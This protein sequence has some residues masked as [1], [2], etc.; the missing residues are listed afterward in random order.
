MCGVVLHAGED[1]GNRPATTVVTSAEVG[2]QFAAAQ[3]AGS[4]S[5]MAR[6]GWSCTRAR[7]SERWSKGLIPRD[8][9]VATS[10]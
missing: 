1:V 8:L 9:Q 7:T 2:V 3:P 10:E 4:D 6:A 5:S